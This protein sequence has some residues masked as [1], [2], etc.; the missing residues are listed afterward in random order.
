MSQVLYN[1]KSTS[2]VIIDEFGKGTTEQD[3]LSLLVAALRKYISDESLCPHI[4]VST[5]LQEIKRH[6]SPSSLLS[7]H[8]FDHVFDGDNIV[9]LYK[10]TDGV[11]NS[12][13]FDVAE[14]AGLD[15]D[16][17]ARARE[18]YKAMCEG[19]PLRPL[20]EQTPR[21]VEY[22]FNI[23]IPELDE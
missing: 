11:S 19:T 22:Y 8:T 16:L 6:L 10:L 13:A 18:I 21:R 14:A 12:F 7:Y 3:A 1:A 2:L 9:F 23:D 4:L 15:K 17:V 5:H 20:F